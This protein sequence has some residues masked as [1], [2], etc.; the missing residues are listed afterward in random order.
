MRWLRGQ[1]TV[2]TPEDPKKETHIVEEGT[3]SWA[4][5]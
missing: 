4:A 3:D 2:A 5:L 1:G